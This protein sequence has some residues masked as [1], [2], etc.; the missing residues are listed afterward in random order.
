[1]AIKLESIN[2]TVNRVL[3]FLEG[4]FTHTVRISYDGPEII[5]ATDKRLLGEGCREEG[6]KLMTLFGNSKGDLSFK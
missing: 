6:F 3:K 2:P 1:M 4:K 5:E